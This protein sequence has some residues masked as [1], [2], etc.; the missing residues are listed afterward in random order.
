MC[1]VVGQE[2]S[3]SRWRGRLLVRHPDPDIVFKRTPERSNFPGP[4]ENVSSVEVTATTVHLT[5]KENHSGSSV[6]TG[7][8]IESF[9]LEDGG[10]SF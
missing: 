10:V 9:S 7:H 5:W 1:M 2:G 8:R 6:V 3:E 4:P